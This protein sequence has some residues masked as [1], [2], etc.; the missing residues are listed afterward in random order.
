MS[1]NRIF[2]RYLPL[3][4]NF[5]IR[6]T[7]SDFGLCLRHMCYALWLVNNKPKRDR[8]YE[9]DIS[10][11][12]M[13]HLHDN[14]RWYETNVAHRRNAAF[15]LHAPGRKH[16]SVQAKYPIP[17]PVTFSERHYWHSD[18]NS[19]KCCFLELSVLSWDATPCQS[20]NM[21]LGGVWKDAPTGAVTNVWNSHSKT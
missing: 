13:T 11:L 12:L 19:Q 9:W 3:C 4:R 18:A 10:L 7:F 1:V 21:L 16:V 14:T 17:V 6:R 20:D 2:E 5:T 15:S 8:Q